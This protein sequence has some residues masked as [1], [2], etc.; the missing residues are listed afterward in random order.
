[1]PYIT[2]PYLPKV[3]MQ[4]AKKVLPEY[5]HYYNNERMHMGINFKRPIELTKW[6]EGI[7]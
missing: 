2:N 3:R 6:C 5:L 4:A 7:D 1:M